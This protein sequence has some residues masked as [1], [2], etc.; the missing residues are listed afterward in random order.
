MKNEPPPIRFY[1]PNLR[2][3]VFATGQALWCRKDM[4]ALTDDDKRE[5]GAVL[6]LLLEDE[7]GNA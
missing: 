6:D 1:S 2:F 4:A 5:A 3:I 7:A